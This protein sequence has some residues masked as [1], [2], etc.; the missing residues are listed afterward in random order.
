MNFSSIIFPHDK[1]PNHSKALDGL[2]GLAVL[3]VILS[4]LSNNNILLFDFLNFSTIGKYGVYLFFVLSS[5]LLDK[6]IISALNKNKA[7]FKYWLNYSLRRFLRIIP[8]FVIALTIN[9][10]LTLNHV[11]WAIPL[12]FNEFIN[13]LLF[14]QGK[15][16]FWSIPVEFK[17]YIVSPI[18]MVVAYRLYKWN[19]ILLS[20]STI[21]LI[22]LSIAL[23]YFFKFNELSLIKYL[24]IFLIG[25]FVA[26]LDQTKPS[27]FKFLSTKI[28]LVNIIAILALSVII[29][30]IPYYFNAVFNTTIKHFHHYIY[31]TFFGVLWAIILITVKFN[32]AIITKFFEYKLLRIF[33]SLSFSL[34]LFHMLVLNF[35]IPLEINTTLKFF[36]VIIG[37]LIVSFISYLCVEK[38]LSKIRLIKVGKP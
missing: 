10:L 28:K 13:H 21:L 29:L 5:Y 15:D 12:N 27:F 26:L 1:N 23:Q 3:I 35:F 16:I 24:P 32:N 6:Q 18:L 17:Y 14:Q 4:H 34:Y 11:K 30:F 7:N 25:S 37:S 33:G 19:T 2:R 31:Y 36:C 38:P 8:L 20:I 9:Y 22:G